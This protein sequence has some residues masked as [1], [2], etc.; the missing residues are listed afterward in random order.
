MQ[1]N[2]QRHSSIL[3]TFSHSLSQHVSY[4]WC[5]FSFFGFFHLFCVIFPIYSLFFCQFSPP[6]TCTSNKYWIYLPAVIFHTYDCLFIWSAPILMKLMC[7]C[8][9]YISN[10]FYGTLHLVGSGAFGSAWSFS[11]CTLVGW[12]LNVMKGV[13]ES[14]KHFIQNSDRRISLSLL[15]FFLLSS[16]SKE[17]PQQ[18]TRVRSSKYQSCYDT[19]PDSIRPAMVILTLRCRMDTPDKSIF[20]LFFFNNC[21]FFFFVKAE[22]TCH[23]I[24]FETNRFWKLWREWSVKRHQLD[25]GCIFYI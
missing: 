3:C 7:K 16:C 4:A 2:W 11:C 13:I 22:D 15:F 25:G 5:A 14:L 10:Q 21:F 24:F 20:F 23:H 8:E 1:F 19:R 18:A 17:N 12:A 6:P 9:L